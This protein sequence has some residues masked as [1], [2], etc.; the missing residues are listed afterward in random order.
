MKRHGDLFQQITEPANIALAHH[1]AKKGKGHY[2]EVK[3]VESNKGKYLAEIRQL[4][5]EKTFRTAEYKTRIIFDGGKEREISKLPYFPDRIV[6]HAIMNIL[7]PIWDKTFVY[8]CY[9]AVPGKGIHAGLGRLRKF[10][11]DAEG[12]RYCLKFDIRKYYP[13]I[14]HK[15]L[16]ALIARKIKCGDTLLLLEEI[17]RSPGG[18]KGIP[19]GNYLSQYF[20]N[21]YL[22]SFDH[23]L[24]G[25][26]QMRYY[27]RYSDDGVILHRDKR[28]LNDLLKEVENYLSENLKLELNP[29]TQV[30]PVED[31]GIDF[32]GYRSF[33]DYM[34]LRKGSAVRF[35]RKLR[36][37]LANY[38]ELE[39]QYVVSS[40]MSHLGWLKHCDSYNF[41]RK[42]ISDPV[43]MQVMAYAS[44]RCGI[45][46]PLVR[47]CDEQSLF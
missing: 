33:R 5:K 12:T 26:R 46:N 23:W 27:I 21:I 16:I 7:Q 20:A 47:Y 6:H 18:D 2:S 11:N 32:L 13:S 43:V 19:I 3:M 10:L 28:E 30:F 37:I 25:K 1:N 39:P 35:K 40:L 15:I 22:N 42:Y 4:L 45:N 31:R 38:E 36:F 41:C 29:K 8:D 17:V 34:L 44:R 14:N 9:S 24:K